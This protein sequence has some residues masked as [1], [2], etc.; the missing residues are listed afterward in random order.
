MS[1]LGFSSSVRR[2]ESRRST[3]TS[4]RPTLLKD[5]LDHEESLF[6]D[7]TGCWWGSTTRDSTISVCVTLP[8]QRSMSPIAL[9]QDRPSTKR[10]DA[11]ILARIGEGTGSVRVS[12]RVRIL[13]LG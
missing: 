7:L 13:Q 6:V 5:P 8:H 1:R 10:F 3:N 11:A 12:R 2:V 4:L 9:W